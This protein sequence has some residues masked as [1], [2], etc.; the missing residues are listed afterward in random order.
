MVRI[1]LTATHT[2]GTVEHMTVIM[3]RAMAHS[4]VTFVGEQLQSLNNSERWTRM[5]ITVSPAQPC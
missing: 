5:Q 3:S 1:S 4:I 2:D